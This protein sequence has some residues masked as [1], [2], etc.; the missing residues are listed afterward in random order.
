MTDRIKQLEQFIAD[1][2]TDPFNHYALALEYS[3]TDKQKALSIFQQL[4][5]ESRDYLPVYYQLAKLYERM[6]QKDNAIKTF[7]AGITLAKMQKDI[8]TLRELSSALDELLC[9]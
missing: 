4:V 7:N 3:N 5:I 6:G 1:D 8:K 2:P 9:D